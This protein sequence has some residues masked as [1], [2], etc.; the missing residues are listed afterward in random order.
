VPWYAFVP[1]CFQCSF[2][3]MCA[4]IMLLAVSTN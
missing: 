1:A 2:N 4:T 3:V